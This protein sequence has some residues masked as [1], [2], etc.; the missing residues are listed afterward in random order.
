MYWPSI[1]FKPKSIWFESYYSSILIARLL[2]SDPLITIVTLLISGSII[3]F[4]ERSLNN[5][6]GL[7]VVIVMEIKFMKLGLTANYINMPPIY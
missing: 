4:N 3:P 1:H 2:F 7:S 6:V 5:R